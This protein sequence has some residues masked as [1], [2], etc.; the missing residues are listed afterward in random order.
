MRTGEFL[1]SSMV[2]PSMNPLTAFQHFMH[3]LPLVS[4]TWNEHAFRSISIA[5]SAAHNFSFL[6]VNLDDDAQN[7]PPSYPE[8]TFQ[9]SSP[10][11][12]I[13]STDA[14]LQ[15][16]TPSHIRSAVTNAGPA[17]PQKAEEGDEAATDISRIK[18][19]SVPL[20][21]KVVVQLLLYPP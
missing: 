5:R 6:A 8:S 15:R 12:L 9:S 1:Y 4:Y 14:R 3:A 16:G 10:I 11:S 21:R 20:F 18:A 19:L 2:Q 17:H 13:F 7:L